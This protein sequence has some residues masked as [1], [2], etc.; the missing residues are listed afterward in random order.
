M[1][2]A[3]YMDETKPEQPDIP[4]LETLER[5]IGYHFSRPGLLIQALTHRSFTAE[6]KRGR[7]QDNERLEFLGDA[8]LE[9]VISHLLFDKYG[10]PDFDEGDLTKMRAYLV[11]ESSLAKRASKIEL[12]RYLRLGRG[13][14][15]TG[16]RS[17]PSILADAFEA[18]TG[19]IY[20]DGGIDAAFSFVT[21]VFGKILDEVGTQGLICDYKSALQE[22]TQARFKSVPLYNLETITGPAHSR[23]FEVS[24]RVEGKELSRGIGKSKK[25]AEQ[26][27][28]KRALEILKQ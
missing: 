5:A 10:P 23:T 20:L 1:T 2:F 11:N 4:R 27:A 18:V 15:Y 16:G 28:A 12:G 25:E 3:T 22:Y 24:L 13:E 9:L 8:V 21:R 19:A 14:E 17:K 26:Q 6:S 7:F